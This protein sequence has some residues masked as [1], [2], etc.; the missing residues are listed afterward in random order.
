GGEELPAELRD[1]F[2]RRVKAEL[3]NL[4]GP[5]EAAVDV[6]YWPASDDD[7]SRPVPIGFPVWNTRLVILDDQLRPVPLGMVG[8]LYLGGVQ[9][10]RGYVGRPDLTAERFIAD[11]FHPGERLYM[12]GDLA[13]RRLQPAGW[14]AALLSWRAMADWSPMSFQTKVFR[15][16]PCVRRSAGQCRNTWCPL[17]S[18]NWPNCRLPPMA[19]WTARRC[20]NRFSPA[21]A[22]ASLRL[23]PSVGW[24]HFMRN[25]WASRRSGGRMTS[26]RSAAIPCWRSN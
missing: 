24:P 5:T 10:A 22:A 17:P 14:C 15:Q 12:T 19:S 16:K 3:H 2:H 25:C 6:S 7:A 4:Y 23:R 1:R 26:S 13:R 20:P 11:P 21:P 9:L 18:W 8:H